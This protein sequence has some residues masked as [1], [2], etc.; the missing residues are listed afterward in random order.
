M[1][2]IDYEISIAERNK[3]SAIFLRERGAQC[4]ANMCHELLPR[5]RNNIATKQVFKVQDFIIPEGKLT[6][7]KEH[8]NIQ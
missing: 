8:N 6:C 5:H 2:K 3:I 7:S 1:S 4:L